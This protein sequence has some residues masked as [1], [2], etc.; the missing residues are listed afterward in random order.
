MPQKKLK[1]HTLDQYLKILSEKT[2]TPGGGSVA[3]LTGALAVGLISMVA[4]YS[5]GKSK[6]KAV[7]RKIAKILSQSQKIRDQFLE[8]VDLDAQAYQKVVAARRLSKSK[9]RTAAQA[10]RKV[11]I[12]ICRIC[13]LAIDLTP[14]LVVYGNQYLLSDIKVALELLE[15]AFQSAQ[16]LINT[17]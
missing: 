16:A 11:P 2:P 12:K 17:E 4:Q 9:Q 5:L 15:A 8:L 10:A 14:Y 3:A 1:N 13:Y 7:E 6:D